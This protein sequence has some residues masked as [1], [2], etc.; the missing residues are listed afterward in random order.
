MIVLEVACPD[1]AH[2]SFPRLHVFVISSDE[3]Y[4][5]VKVGGGVAL[6]LSHAAIRP[7]CD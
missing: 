3:H 2:I 7:L 5:F 6:Q 4:V 1:R